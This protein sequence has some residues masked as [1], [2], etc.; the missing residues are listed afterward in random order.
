[1]SSKIVSFRLGRRAVEVMVK[2]MTTPAGSAAL[3]AWPD[4]G[5]G[6]L[7]PGRLWQLHR[8]GRWRAD[9]RLP[10]ARR[11]CRRQAGDDP[12]TAAPIEGL[13][14]VQRAFVDTAPSSVAT[15]RRAWSR[16][17]GRCSSTTR[18]PPGARSSMRWAATSAAAPA[19]RRS[20]RRSKRRRSHERSRSMNVSRPLRPAVADAEGGHVSG[21]TPVH[22]RPHLPGHAPPQGRAQPRPSRAAFAASTCPRRSACRASSAP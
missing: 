4:R 5:Q 19:T 20:S 14:A 9:G 15:A 3:P 18:T 17:P 21:R 11:G 1:M 16:S 12:R 22:D 8:A 6:R 2:P 13:D 7:P 10:A